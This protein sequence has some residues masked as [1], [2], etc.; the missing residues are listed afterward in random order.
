MMLAAEKGS[1]MMIKAEGEDAELAMDA[2]LTL[3]AAGF[4]EMDLT[5]YET[6]AEEE[7][8]A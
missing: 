5:D 4:N 1:S 7:T 6:E 3:V 8:E 2:L